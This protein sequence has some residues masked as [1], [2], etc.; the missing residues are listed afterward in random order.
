MNE[1]RVLPTPVRAVLGALFVGLLTAACA[2]VPAPASTYGNFGL[3]VAAAAQVARPRDEVV[4][5]LRERANSASYPYGNSP[6]FDALERDG[7]TLYLTQWFYLKK[8]QWSTRYGL[9]P[10]GSDA[11]EVE[12]LLP[13]ELSLSYYYARAALEVI[14]NCQPVSARTG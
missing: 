3:S 10:I 6:G 2:E 8:G 1:K 9:H 11:T 12:V 4:R 13:V 5:C 14:A 7:D